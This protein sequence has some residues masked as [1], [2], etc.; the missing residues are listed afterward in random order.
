ML[1]VGCQ[2]QHRVYLSIGVARCV[3]SY[4]LSG[5]HVA[6]LYS[7][8]CLEIAGCHVLSRQIRWLKSDL[9]HMQHPRFSSGEEHGSTPEVRPLW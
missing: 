6:A 7:N 4:D 2:M 3:Y 1:L 9:A 5:C 8:N